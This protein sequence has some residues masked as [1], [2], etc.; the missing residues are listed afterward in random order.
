MY[1][2]HFSNFGRPPVPDELCKDSV[3]RRPRF[4]RRRFLK[5]FSIYGYGGHLGQWTATIL[6]IFHSP[7]PEGLQMKFEQH[8]PRG[9]REGVIWNSE[10]FSHTNELGSKLD[11]A[12]K[13]SNVQR[14]QRRSHLKFYN[15]FPYKS[16]GKQL[17]LTVKK[18]NVNV[19]PLF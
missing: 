5:V 18:S 7:A 15:F 9:S 17:D 10:H 13:M 2:H 19:R 11:L 4:W 6:A 12:I 8:W 3:K 14:L 16:L 1:D